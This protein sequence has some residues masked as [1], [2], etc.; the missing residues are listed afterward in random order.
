MRDGVERLAS[1]RPENGPLLLRALE[2]RGDQWST[3]PLSF[4]QQRLWFLDRWEPGSA[5][6]N[7]PAALRLRG[8][9]DVRALEA[10]LVRSR[11]DTRFFAPA[12]STS[13]EGPSRSFGNRAVS[14]SHRFVFRPL[15][16]PER[17]AQV[18]AL[19]AEEAARP[20]DLT[21]ASYSAPPSFAWRSRTTSSF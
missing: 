7:L 17:E 12:S 10:S 1:C 4:A 3:F 19:A 16:V 20:F 21:L 5:A 6:Y 11:G 18:L 2:E 14:G 8:A 9:L 13:T 15:T